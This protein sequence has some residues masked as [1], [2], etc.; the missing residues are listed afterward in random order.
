V[1]AP[2]HTVSITG[3]RRR[4]GQTIEESRAVAR[5]PKMMLLINCP[6]TV[7]QRSGALQRIARRK[8]EMAGRSTA[9]C[10]MIMSLC[11][12]TAPVHYRNT[13]DLLGRSAIMS[14]VAAFSSRAPCYSRITCRMAF[15][16]VGPIYSLELRRVRR[17]VSTVLTFWRP[18]LPHGYSY[19]ASCARPG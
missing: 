6:T 17:L 19:K 12:R 11:W 14:I 2:Y 9:E 1:Y 3:M 15:S 8:M 10:R 16:V 4:Q 7:P 5:K 18:L 13:S